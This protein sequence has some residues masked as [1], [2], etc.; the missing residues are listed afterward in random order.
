MELWVNI[1]TGSEASLGRR[2][3]QLK[4][5]VWKGSTWGGGSRQEI[6]ILQGCPLLFLIAVQ[7]FFIPKP[8]SWS[9]DYVQLEVRGFGL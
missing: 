5:V 8:V 9:P 2:G 3:I 7:S 4:G 1:D 6:S